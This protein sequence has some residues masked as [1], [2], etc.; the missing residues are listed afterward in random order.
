MSGFKYKHSE[1]L[2]LVLQAKKEDIINEEE[3]KIMKEFVITKEPNLDLELEEYMGDK[4]LRK[5]IETM[6]LLS[7]IT[8]MSSP[9][10]NNLIDMKRKKQKSHKEQK[11]KQKKKPYKNEE[12]DNFDVADCDIGA[13][14]TI[15]FKKKLEINDDSD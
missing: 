8:Q 15:N 14:P 9:L 10:D 5:L 11:I 13:S 7:G 1:I 2:S 3:K 6:K 4:D 12:E